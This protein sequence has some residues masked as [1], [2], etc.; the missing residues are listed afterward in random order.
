MLQNLCK[1]CAGANSATNKHFN[2]KMRY[3]LPDFVQKLCH[4]AQQNIK[5][6]GRGL[7]AT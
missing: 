5:L 2:T 4:V 3:I 7:R 6:R 1:T